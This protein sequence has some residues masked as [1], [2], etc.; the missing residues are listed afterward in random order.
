ME[1]PATT[2]WRAAQAPTSSM[3]D[4]GWTPLP[5]PAPPRPSS[6]IGDADG[7][8]FSSIENLIGSSLGDTLTGDDGANVFR[9]G[10]GVDIIDGGGDKDTASYAT[11]S[12]GVTVD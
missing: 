6:S 7:D 4:V 2:R 10:G 5:M 1:A 3:A 9:P 12:L 11:S 8:I